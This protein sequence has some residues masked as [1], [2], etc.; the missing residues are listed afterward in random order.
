MTNCGTEQTPFSLCF[1]GEG[2]GMRVS[3][4]IAQFIGFPQPLQ[5]LMSMGWPFVILPL[6]KIELQGQVLL[7]ILVNTQKR[8]EPQDL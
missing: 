3:Y 5:T 7:W 6:T 1:E 4:E 2:L 8:F